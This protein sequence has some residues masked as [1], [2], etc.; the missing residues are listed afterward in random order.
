MLRLTRNPHDT[1][2]QLPQIQLAEESSIA[3]LKRVAPNPT[4]KRISKY[5]QR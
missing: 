5:L 3:G 2:N 1:F 4:G